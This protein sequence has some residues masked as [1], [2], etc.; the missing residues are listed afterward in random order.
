MSDANSRS[1]FI[2]RPDATP[3]VC[4]LLLVAAALVVLLAAGA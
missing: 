3:F 2:W 4:V 1:R